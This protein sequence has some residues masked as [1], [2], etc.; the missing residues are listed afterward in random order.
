MLLLL[1][2]I[3]IFAKGYNMEYSQ[4]IENIWS[5][6]LQLIRQ[7]YSES[8]FNLWFADTQPIDLTEK[9]F[10]IS[11]PTAFKKNIISSRHR[12]VVEQALQE[13]LGF[14]IEAA[15]LTEAEAQQYK[16]SGAI[17]VSPSQRAKETEKQAPQIIPVTDYTFDNFIV[18]SSNTFAHAA[19][20][21]VA[22]SPAIAYNPLF[23]WGPPGIG[24]THLMYAIQN[25]LIK[26]DPTLKCIYV[27]GED[28]TNEVVDAIRMQNTHTF[29]EKYRT[30]DVLIIDDIQFIA[31]KT[32]TQ[33]EFFHTFDSLYVENKQV[34]I[35][36]D[37]PPKEMKTL[38]DRLK[39]RFESGL[40]ADIQS[41]D[42][43]LRM[44]IIK[45]KA[46]KMN[47]NI[48]N[49][50]I[51][52][53]ADRLK[54]NVRQI[55]GSL[56]KLS[57]LSL[58]SGTPITLEIAKGAVSDIATE[59]EPSNVT[60]DK[61][62]AAVSIKYKIPT[63]EIKSRKQ[64]SNVVNARHVCIYLI[65][66]LTDLTLSQIGQLFSRDHTTAMSSLRKIENRISSDTSFEAE[67]NELISDVKES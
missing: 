52:Y 37:K 17:P 12:D 36:A 31:G 35:T 66:T 4:E 7:S 50:V 61:I 40:I 14:Y 49:D 10:I 25:E 45:N 3:V 24:K 8:T 59:R 42:I 39:S 20:L 58:L 32:S 55:E 28:F 48:P 21:A 47:I 11:T 56:K 2:I 53:M 44:A 30:V 34:I 43:E 19:C 5:M 15:V 29:R 26:N 57:A 6:A 41:P 16:K 51:T 63:E 33:E 62:F 54:N 13:V 23:I 46:A 1:Y 60:V 9:K 27:K 65:R 67:I 64:T 22:K 18:G 38:E